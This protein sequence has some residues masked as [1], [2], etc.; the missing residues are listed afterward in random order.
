MTKITPIDPIILESLNL[1]IVVAR[2]DFEM[3]K[4]SIEAAGKH[5][6]LNIRV[7]RNEP[8]ETRDV[9]GTKLMESYTSGQELIVFHDPAVSGAGMDFI[10]G[11]E[12]E[13][14]VR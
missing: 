10:I 11:Q 5:C 8:V 9:S 7:Y 12:L 14:V 3:H 6:E 4:E 1:H 2:R 13:R